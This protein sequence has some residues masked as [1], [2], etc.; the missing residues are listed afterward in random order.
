MIV[1]DG[2][3]WNN[4]AFHSDNV[5][6]RGDRIRNTFQ[7]SQLFQCTAFTVQKAAEISLALNLA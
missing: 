6:L 4:S 7:N 3:Y 2:Y 1:N 5:G